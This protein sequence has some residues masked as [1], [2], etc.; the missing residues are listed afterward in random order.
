[1]FFHAEHHL[2]P[3][4]PTGHLHVLASRLDV[5]VPEVS[6]RQVLRLGGIEEEKQGTEC[7]K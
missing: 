2:F 5:A 7:G 4:V 3:A 6:R 1:M